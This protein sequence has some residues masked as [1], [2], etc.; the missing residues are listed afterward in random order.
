MV[1]PLLSGA[2]EDESSARDLEYVRDLGLIARDDPLRIANP[3]CAEYAQ[4]YLAEFEYRFNRRFNLPDIIPGLA[5]VALRTP[6]MSKRLL[7][8]RLARVSPPYSPWG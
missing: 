6:P 2:S 7:E 1:E 4:R 5:C 8:L 3:I